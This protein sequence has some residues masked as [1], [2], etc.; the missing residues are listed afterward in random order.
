M[1]HNALL[2]ILL[3][4]VTGCSTTKEKFSDKSI[5]HI[6][7]SAKGDLNSGSYNDAAEAFALVD[8]MF[9]Y[10]AKANDAQVMSAYCYFLEGNYQLA[11]RKLDVFLHYHAAHK[12]VAYAMYL[13]AMCF[14]TQISYVG[15]DAKILTDAKE[16]FSELLNRFPTS[17]YAQAASEKI[18]KL[19]NILAEHEMEIGRFY[20]KQ[21]SFLSAMYRYNYVIS[22][23]LDAACSQE[24][25]YRVVKCCMANRLIENAEK[26]YNVLAKNF[27]N[28]SWTKKAALLIKQNQ[29]KY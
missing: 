13:R 20:E 17:K 9:P 10:S 5:D 27:P 15:R 28:S 1:Y 16:K 21:N 12:L 11:I 24:A 14:Y 2:V 6:Y 8:T 3:F 29:K 26:S 22:N 23:Y 7:S 25:Y 4:V 18:L 19:N